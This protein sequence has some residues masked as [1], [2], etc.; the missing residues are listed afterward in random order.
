MWVDNWLS[1]GRFGT[2][3]TAT[4]GARPRALELYEW[5][6]RLSADFLHDLSHLEICL[7]NAY[8]RALLPATVAGESHWTEPATIMHLFPAAQRW[9]PRLQQNVDTNDVPR[10]KIEQAR[11]EASRPSNNPPLAGKVIAETMFGFWTY[12]TSDAHEKTIWVPYLHKVFPIGTDR[13]LVHRSLSNLNNFRNR[14][15][16]HE[17]IL[18]GSEDRRRQIIHMVR[19]LS[20]DVLRHIKQHSEVSSILAAR[21]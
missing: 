11:K 17:P 20:P 9:D 1:A 10:K 6:T 13:R 21:P 15:A 16:H 14:V 7:R 2:Y 12:L 4:N 8:D 19:L 3:L 5:N 18:V